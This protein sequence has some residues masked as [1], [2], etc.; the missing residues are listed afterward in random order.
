MSEELDDLKFIPLRPPAFDL[1]K[2]KSRFADVPTDAS[3]E[4]RCRV[5]IAMHL[6]R[7]PPEAI[8][9]I[10]EHAWGAVIKLKHDRTAPD[11][12]KR[13]TP[14]ITERFLSAVEEENPHLAE[15]AVADKLVWKDIVESKF[16]SNGLARPCG[17][18]FP[19]PILVQRIVRAGSDLME[20][21]A[22][23]DVGDKDK[24]NLERAIQVLVDS[25]MCVSLLQ[26]TEI[27]KTVKKFIKLSTKTPK[28]QDLDIFT[29]RTISS[30]TKTNGKSMSPLQ[31]LESLLQYWKDV[32]AKSGVAIHNSQQ[33]TRTPRPEDEA[34]SDLKAAESCQTWRELYHL[35]HERE[36]TRRV[37]QGMRESRER[38]AQNQPKIVK[39]RPAKAKHEA[40]LNR[41]FGPKYGSSSASLPPTKNKLQVLREE[42]KVAAVWQ[43]STPGSKVQA[44]SFGNAVAFAGVGKS[45]K[46]LKPTPAKTVGTPGGKSM[47]G[48]TKIPTSTL[49]KKLSKSFRK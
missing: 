47:K 19:W 24:H 4:F 40:I 43:K 28:A 9:M 32:A 16:P 34:E 6:E 10:G 11:K 20:L 29:S 2:A 35:L 31:Q 26:E 15:S 37:N 5:V 44:N 30:S 22:T 21:Y 8:G 18:L 49:R 7:Y 23:D 41:P 38:I 36:Q 46:K 17:L 25:P 27:G 1:K 45:A 13:R 42:S 33:L 48:P 14:A 39:V 12:G 3:L